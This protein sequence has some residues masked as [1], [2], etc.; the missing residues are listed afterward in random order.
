MIGEGL[1]DKTTL[2]PD[3]SEG[4]RI[5]YIWGSFPGRRDNKCP[6]PETMRENKEEKRYEE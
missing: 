5:V 4:T 2:N 3:P 1:P 6:N